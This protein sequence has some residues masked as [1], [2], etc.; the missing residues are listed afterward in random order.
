M[1][2]LKITR[3][4]TRRDQ[5]SLEKYLA[6][7]AK[8]DILTPDQE[9]DLF[10]R[11]RQG[12]STALTKI[13]RHNLRFVVSVAKQYQDMGMWLGDLINEGNIGMIK[14]AQRFDETKGFKF[15]SYAVWW[16]RQSILQAINEKGRMIRLPLNVNSNTSKV[17]I[18]R[19]EILQRK[20]REPTTA[21]LAKATGLSKEVVEKCMRSYA[22]CKSLDAPLTD[23]SEDSMVNLLEDSNIRKPDYDL[24]VK[25]SQQQEVQ[26][27]INTLPPRQKTIIAMYFGIG[28]PR[29]SSLSDIADYFG[30]SRERVR[31]IKDRSLRK[32]RMKAMRDMASSA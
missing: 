17:M 30:L 29:S 23:D 26:H 22:K 14:A 16:I 13:L 4:I 8:Y 24:A 15:I 12:D 28:Q 1:R 3:S 32:L 2:A 21:E 6:E 31:Q 10:K 25:E 7:I 19:F 20:E 9:L 5:K 27:L 11:Y 18:K